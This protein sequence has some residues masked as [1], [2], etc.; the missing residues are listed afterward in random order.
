MGVIGSAKLLQALARDSLLPGL[1]AFGQGT[2]KTD[3]PTLAILITHV[4]AQFT[5][6]LDI[7]RIASF[8]TTSYLTTFLFTNL[9]CFL[10]K[11]S[12]APNF[13]PSFHYFN[14]QT[15][16]AGTIV[17]ALTMFFV[18]GVFASACLGILVLLFLLIHYTTPPKSW[19]DV[20]QNLIYHQ[21]RKYLLRLRQE[22]VKYWRPQILLLV[23]NPRSQYQLV[24]FCNHM[25]K[26]ALYV[27]GH[28]IVSQDF[29]AKVDEARR[30]QD[31][32]TKYVDVGKIKAFVNISVSPTLEWG[33]RNIVLSSGLGGM[34]PNIAVL[35]FYN[36]VR[37]KEEEISLA[38]AS[39][40]NTPTPRK[41]GQ[42][43]ARSTQ[44]EGENSA[45]Q[46]Q[47]GASKASLPTDSFLFED[48][49]TAG[50]YVT[51]LED[52]LIRLRINV[53][54]AR[55]FRFLELPTANAD[56]SK[57]YI[58]LWPIQ[59]SAEIVSERVENPNVLTTNFDTYTLILQ[60]GCILNTV[61]AWKH[62]FKL[63]VAVFVEYESD[64]R[65]EQERVRTLLDNLRIEAEVL[66]CW[67]ASGDLKF[68]EIFVNGAPPS[69]H[70]REQMAT[71]GLHEQGGCWEDA[72][73]DA[74]GN[75]EPQT[76]GHSGTD[77]DICK[78]PSLRSGSSFRRV[79]AE[80]SAKSSAGISERVASK[81]RHTMSGISKLGLT[82][83]MRTH[84]LHADLIHGHESSSEDT[85]SSDEGN[86]PDKVPGDSFP[87][88]DVVESPQ[89]RLINSSNDVPRRTKPQKGV[90]EEPFG[91][92]ILPRTQSDSRNP[93]SSNVLRD[94]AVSPG[95]PRQMSRAASNSL[96]GIKPES[97]STNSRQGSKR[98][99]LEGI[100]S[101]TRPQ[102][103][104]RTTVTEAIGGPLGGTQTLNSKRPGAS[105]MFDD[106]RLPSREPEETATISGY[107]A[108]ESHHQ[109][110]GTS[111]TSGYPSS[112][113][114]PL[115]FNELPC[116]AQHLILNELIQQH[117]RKAAVV[118]TTLP[119]P[120]KG[121]SHSEADSLRYLRDL[122]LLCQGLPPTLLVHS[123]SMTV[124][125]NL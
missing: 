56:T 90:V 12:S 29:D 121:T 10:L 69:A 35:G 50:S 120:I 88:R 83:G 38:A 117:S 72:A 53:A 71:L 54:V 66:V 124:T 43:E 111:G 32:W 6:L 3:E 16:A 118:F 8:V 112:Q 59:M 108:Y 123:N 119:S 98:K 93:L 95:A 99:I 37:L 49:V 104:W 40:E 75:E 11:V 41:G 103:A 28:V 97:S 89:P 48:G 78:R 122:D 64:V 68:Y 52:L 60:L 19:G 113:A 47:A 107:Q 39:S 5:M 80:H 15:A 25:K 7:N 81:R 114:Q 26:G 62:S 84:C 36:S 30:Q 51:I 85:D 31:A 65:E 110:E 94:R 70:V 79:S 125:T 109:G 21:V 86:I 106:S 100:P 87:F 58:D 13:R 18:D 42:N 116:R 24:Q 4:V 23:N 92:K 14:W 57:N 27:L 63:R 34:R 1:S 76:D 91:P 67:L 17:S 101:R 46:H 44:I 73:E 77:D 45:D 55:G 96:V 102:T 9:A 20:G 74:K 105:I 82:L 115:S 61:P 33:V 2:R 22:H